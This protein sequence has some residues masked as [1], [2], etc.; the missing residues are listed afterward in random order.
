MTT[1]LADENYN[2]MVFDAIENRQ[3]MVDLTFSS[4]H[5][6]METSVGKV[7]FINDG[8]EEKAV[9]AQLL[10]FLTLILIGILT[11]V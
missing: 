2:A 8:T 4:N 6:D 11:L 9:K 5:L 1:H 7:I 10:K 3:T